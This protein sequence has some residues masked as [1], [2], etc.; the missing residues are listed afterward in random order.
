MQKEF[1]FSSVINSMNA[2]N[3]GWVK[4]L[5][6]AALMTLFIGFLL[7]ILFPVGVKAASP[8]VAGWV[9]WW[10]EED[11]LEE[12]IDNMEDIDIIYPFIYEIE[13]G[14]DIKAK[15]DI[16]DGVWEDL[17]EEAEDER[18]EIIPTI[19][20]FNG[21]G[22]H[23]VLSDKKQRRQLVKDIEDLVD[24][25]NFDGINIDFE[26][27]WAET[28]DYYSLFLEELKDELGRDELTCTVEARMEPD[29]RWRPDAM[30]AEIKYANDFKEINKHCDWVELMTYDQ[31]RADL[32]YNDLRKGLPYNPVADI[33]WVEHVLELALEDIDEDKIMLGIPTYGRAY[34]VT[35]APEW[36]RDYTRVASVDHSRAV[37]LADDIYNVP[38]GR[39]DGGEAIITYFPEDSVWKIFNALPT[40][41]GT[42]AGYEAAAKAL[43]VAT[44]AKVELPVRMLTWGD[45]KA[46]E[47]KWDLAKEYDLKGVAFFKF[48]GEEDE[49]IWDIF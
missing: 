35:V 40:P 10:T 6:D 47:D 43:L 21:E 48:D 17:L 27:K 34:D 1:L 31:Q 23:A 18:V 46:A 22:I 44:L 9:P 25:N 36:Y 14:G 7:W 33:D 28:K 11:G 20:W 15:V 37:E 19:A 30:P 42:P 8:E 29:H 45:A 32:Y 4:K 49:D 13:G 26:E 12:V 41:E 3:K 16:E 2:G 38:I 24:D 5:A 39:T